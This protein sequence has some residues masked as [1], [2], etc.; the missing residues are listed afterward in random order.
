MTH[1]ISQTVKA[2]DLACYFPPWTVT[3]I[4][5]WEMTRPSIS[6]VAIDTLLFSRIGVPLFHRYQIISR[7]GIHAAFRGRHMRGIGRGIGLSTSSPVRQGD[8]GTYVTVIRSGLSRRYGGCFSSTY[9]YLLDSFSGLETS[10][11]SEGARSSRALDMVSL[12]QSE[13]YTVQA[14]MD[15]ALPRFAGL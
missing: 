8:G 5:W 11:V 2:A 1:D 7:K 12:P 3:R 15:L 10:Q 9:S 13:A 4:Q 6:G 14:M